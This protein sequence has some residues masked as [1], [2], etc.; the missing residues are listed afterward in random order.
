MQHDLD[1]H[2]PCFMMTSKH[3]AFRIIMGEH[4]TEMFQQGSRLAKFGYTIDDLAIMI[5]YSW[6]NLYLTESMAE[7]IALS[8][9]ERIAN[10][11]P[12]CIIPDNTHTPQCVHMSPF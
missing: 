2:D 5:R 11:H 4:H 12:S 9:K 10:G 6:L 8:I 7:L 3:G 1:L